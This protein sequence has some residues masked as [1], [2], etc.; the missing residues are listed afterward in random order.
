MKTI[1][2][3][4]FNFLLYSFCGL[5]FAMSDD[6]M[7]RIFR[8]LSLSKQSFSQEWEVSNIM[9]PDKE[10]LAGISQMW[11]DE[12]AE[13][14]AK[15]GGGDPEIIKQLSANKARGIEF[16]S[17]DQKWIDR[18]TLSYQDIKKWELNKVAWAG[19]DRE[20]KIRIIPVGI[21]MIAVEDVDPN[22][23]KVSTDK[24]N[25]LLNHLSNLYIPHI[26]SLLET[27]PR[28]KWNIKVAENS[29]WECYTKTEKGSIHFFVDSKQGR[30]LKIEYKSPSGILLSRS[31]L[32]DEGYSK[33]V[34]TVYNPSG[35]KMS[36]AKWRLVREGK[37]DTTKVDFAT[38]R[39]GGVVNAVINGVEHKNMTTDE[40]IRN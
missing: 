4:G 18:I 1:T 7:Y 37:L 32:V 24:K 2:F 21:D 23:V 36:S 6:E 27:V 20:R 33:F 30:F 39:P 9:Y 34:T 28:D 25:V 14:V 10:K 11:D 3:I 19:S 29:I 40:F 22:F 17:K 38:L 12:I 35:E 15:D 16:C 13:E 31:E 5:L 26:P 8:A